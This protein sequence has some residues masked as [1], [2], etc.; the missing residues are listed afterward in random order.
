MN[1]LN[2]P[3]YLLCV[4]QRE[5]SSGRIHCAGSGPTGLKLSPTTTSRQPYTTALITTTIEEFNACRNQLSSGSSG[6]CNKQHISTILGSLSSTSTRTHKS[7]MQRR[8][9]IEAEN[10]VRSSIDHYD[11]QTTTMTYSHQRL[12]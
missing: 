4:Q 3:C 10:L 1:T 7:I 2:L 9:A 8:D 11:L 5:K 6:V 12:L